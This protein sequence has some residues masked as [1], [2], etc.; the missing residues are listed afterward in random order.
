MAWMRQRC[1]TLLSLAKQGWFVGAATVLMTTQPFI[2]SLSKN[3]ENSCAYRLLQLSLCMTTNSQRM[4]TRRVARTPTDDYLS[5]STTFVTEIAKLAIS[6]TFYS[7]LPPSA[8]SHRQL[9]RSDMLLFAAPAFV[10]FINN[11]LIFIILTYVNS[12][13][14]QILSSLKTVFTGILFRVVLKR[15]LSDVQ[16][17]AILLLACGV[18]PRAAEHS[19]SSRLGERA[20][21]AR[22]WPRLERRTHTVPNWRVSSCTMEVTMDVPSD[23][24]V[25]CEPR[26]PRRRPTLPY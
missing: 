11:N 12:T 19:S 2:T 18:R 17:V 16:A 22:A 14:Y 1:S 21:G 8:R 26:L 3:D 4:L 13:T 25:P 20:D 15:I 5:V 23:V 10:Y 6:L 9:A 24:R 7:M